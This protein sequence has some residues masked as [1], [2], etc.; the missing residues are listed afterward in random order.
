MLARRFPQKSITEPP[1]E[2]EN[3]PSARR[4][5]EGSIVFS[6]EREEWLRSLGELVQMCNEA[7][8]RRSPGRR[9]ASKPLSLEYMA[10]RLDVDD[11]INGLMVLTKDQGWLQGFVTYTTFTTWHRHFRWDSTHPCLSMLEED[12]DLGGARAAIDRD[13][14]LARQLQ[15]EVHAGDPENEGI[16]WPGIAEI[17]LLGA[18]GCG[19]WLVR[20]VIALL[21]SSDSQYRFIV[22]QATDN[23]VPFYERMGFVRVGAISS[24]TKLAKGRAS[25]KPETKT[26]RKETPGASGSKK[27]GRQ[28]TSKSTQPKSSTT[29][30][31]TCST[32]SAPGV[33]TVVATA[34]SS[35]DSATAIF[36]G[37]PYATAV[38]VAAT[39]TKGQSPHSDS[40]SGF[41][42]DSTLIEKK[43]SPSAS[44]P[45]ESFPK[46]Q[47]KTL[48]KTQP[49]A[50]P[51]SQPKNQ[52]KS[53]PKSHGKGKK[54]GQ[55][56]SQANGSAQPGLSSQALSTPIKDEAHTATIDGR[57]RK[58][59][60]QPPVV[61][62]VFSPHLW[63]TVV[64][65]ESC[66]SVAEKYG[67]EVSDVLFL[68][69][70][71]FA[72]LTATALLKKGTKLQ[73]PIKQTEATVEAQFA[74]E[75]QRFRVLESDS[76]LRREAER[77]GVSTSDLLE[78]N[79]SRIKGLQLSSHLLKGTRL[80][81]SGS[82]R[83]FEEYCHWT[84]PED[85]NSN[86]CPS[87][88]MALKLKP[89]AERV[90]KSAQ[91]L[92]AAMEAIS[93]SERPVAQPSGKRKSL[94]QT[95][96]VEGEAQARPARQL[97]NRVV[98]VEGEEEHP[99]WYVLTYLP[100]LQWCHV[101]PLRQCGV[102]ESGASAGR[103]RWMLLPEEEGGEKDVGAGRCK[104]M[105]ALEIKKTKA[106]ADEEEWDIVGFDLENV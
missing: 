20:L 64:A 38:A 40:G 68:N 54:Q 3:V 59:I 73:V 41:V 103:P 105:I 15:C 80:L 29:A 63:H 77:A 95:A 39:A 1:Y 24:S 25:L 9:D 85:D 90:S 32:P 46:I 37:T 88:M 22:V 61:Q 81:V 70:R 94:L 65:V 106:N 5:L 86:N 53:Q 45:L 14:S 8:R 2:P 48:P 23:S 52:P 83:E 89:H 75:K 82:E 10:D 7:V 44:A 79:K 84:Y 35:T 58:A 11:P 36:A 27:R 78:R 57:K 91:Q 30:P 74:S 92:V 51:K 96:P 60:A 19:A 76:T 71:R 93:V 56:L 13:G 87:Y 49:K 33:A 102:F 18:I 34:I 100:D 31:R 12:D 21:E 72:K 43:N 62:E 98:T 50:Q 101:A 4:D 47:P 69:S 26:K 16:V 28:I 67:V 99:Y 97:F 17:S 6:P 104:A 66:A 42:S 55:G